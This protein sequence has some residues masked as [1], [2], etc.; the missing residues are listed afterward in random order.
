MEKSSS[1]MSAS[2][3]IDDPN[4]INHDQSMK[5]RI[6]PQSRRADGSIRK[7][8]KVRPGFVPVEDVARF[9]PSRV[10]KARAEAAFATSNL[11]QNDRRERQKPA[12]DV[13]DKEHV[14]TID[15]KRSSPQKA[16]SRPISQQ[17]P[18]KGV[19]KQIQLSESHSASDNPKAIEK[20]AIEEIP[21]S[22]DDDDQNDVQIQQD[23][24]Y[25]IDNITK[26]LE[27]INIKQKK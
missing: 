9:V 14:S 8:R 1:Q 21:D 3:I 7:E 12:P 10:R 11:N 13:S 16:E 23:E 25:T 15:E 4:A 22:W 6:I 24:V 5:Q 26:S 20:P 2:G 19:S 17:K 18:S 27:K